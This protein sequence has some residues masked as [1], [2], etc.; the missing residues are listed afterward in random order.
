MEAAPDPELDP[1]R[2][3]LTQG[4]GHRRTPAPPPSQSNTLKSYFG[5]GGVVSGGGAVVS[6][7]DGRGG[8]SGRATAK[9]SLSLSASATPPPAAI[10][11]YLLQSLAKFRADRAGDSGT[12]TYTACNSTT[13]TTT[14]TTTSSATGNYDNTSSS[15]SSSSNSSSSSC[16]S[17]SS[18]SSS[19]PTPSVVANAARGR[20]DASSDGADYVPST[21]TSSRFF[22]VSSISVSPPRPSTLPSPDRPSL[23][24]LDPLLFRRDG[25]QPS[26]YLPSSLS[27]HVSPLSIASTLSQSSGGSALLEK[28]HEYT[29][30]ILFARRPTRPI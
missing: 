27:S 18:S 11:S 15:S 2:K 16:S 10:P 19:T 1:Y 30:L 29:S 7:G 4:G 28:V 3:M 21:P 23:A 17:S 25:A 24:P 14:T 22:Q 12:D 13:T 9:V 20:G 8:G 26:I 5:F 6:G